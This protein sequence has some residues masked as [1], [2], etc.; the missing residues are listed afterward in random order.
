MRNP[1]S[2]LFVLLILS[3]AC[4]KE[5]DLRESMLLTLS[6]RDPFD[7]DLLDTSYVGHLSW[8]LIK[9]NDPEGNPVEFSIARKYG[10]FLLENTS[11][12]RDQIDYHFY[13]PN[14]PVQKVRFEFADHKM[15]DRQTNRAMIVRSIDRVWWNGEP[16]KAEQGYFKV[17][18]HP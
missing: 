10:A 11:K 15:T 17:K 9:W 16:L 7:N 5:P 4:K 13:F 1:S 3:A 2:V 12:L 18:I 8:E 14:I 6:V